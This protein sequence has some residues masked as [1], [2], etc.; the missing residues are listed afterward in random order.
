MDPCKLCMPCFQACTHTFNSKFW[1]IIG[2]A[3]M[4]QPQPAYTIATPG[5]QN[6]ISRLII[7][8]MSSR[9]KDTLFQVLRIGSTQE[10]FAI[11]IGLDNQQVCLSHSL[12]H[13][14]CDFAR[15]GND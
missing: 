12:D 10:A 3:Q 13:G 1:R 4:C 9:A 15:V 7:R 2:A 5:L 8:E 11:M 6:S 14:W